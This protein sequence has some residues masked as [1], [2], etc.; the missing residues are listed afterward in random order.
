MTLPKACDLAARLTRMS[1][2]ID[3]NVAKKLWGK[4]ANAVKVAGAFKSGPAPP[5]NPSDGNGTAKKNWSKLATAVKVAGAFKSA[6]AS[7]GP[8]GSLSKEICVPLSS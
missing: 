3:V 6:A 2:Q 7:S 1:S 5:T 8:V 4:H